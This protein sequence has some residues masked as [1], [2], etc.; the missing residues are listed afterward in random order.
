[1]TN[2]VMIPVLIRFDVIP[3]LSILYCLAMPVRVSITIRLAR[4]QSDSWGMLRYTRI[5]VTATYQNVLIEAIDIHSENIKIISS[6]K[7]QKHG[8]RARRERL[9]ICSFTQLEEH[10]QV[11]GHTL[12]VNRVYARI[13]SR[14]EHK[15]DEQLD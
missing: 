1:M 10:R 5:L 14:G 8:Q 11:S 7:N 4:T 12:L 15:Q 13:G 3:I 9:I 6:R 2:L